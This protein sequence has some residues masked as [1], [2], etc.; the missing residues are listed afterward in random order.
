MKITIEQWE[1]KF[2]FE[3]ENDGL[4]IHDIHELWERFLL[5]IGYQYGTIKEKYD[6]DVGERILTILNDYF[7]NTDH[8]QCGNPDCK[9]DG[10]WCYHFTD[11][12]LE[13][14]KNRLY[15]LSE[16]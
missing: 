10:G 6:F 15:E 13:E 5:A 2:T 9:Y 4:D 3:T 14:L 8:L 12:D 11:K 1:E 16:E 7:E